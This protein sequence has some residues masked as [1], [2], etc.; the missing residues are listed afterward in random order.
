V[1]DRE[2][3]PTKSRVLLDVHVPKAWIGGVLAAVGVFLVV[4]VAGF[5]AVNRIETCD[6]CHLIRDEVATYKETAHYDAG[7]GCQ[8]CHTKP[9]VFNYLIR[10]LQG[11][12]NLI[13]FVSNTY[14]RPVTTHVGA[15][16]C[17]QCHSNEELERDKVVGNIRINHKGLREAGY[18]CLACH[19][20]ISH[21]GTQLAVARTSQNPMS[22]C[23]R[24][25]DGEQLPD[26]CDIC[27]IGGV[28]ATAP[29]V[30]MDVRIRPAQ[31]AGCHTGRVF[32]TDCH[33]GLQMPHPTRWN[34]QHGGVVLD[35]G[36]NICVSC[37]LKDDKDFCIDCH[38]VPM[39]HPSGYRSNHGS[40]AQNNKA[41]CEK[42]HGQNSCIRCHGLQMPHPSGWSSS[43]TG[44]G[45]SS[46]SLCT[47][48]HST[49]YCTNCH[50]VSMPHSSGFIADHPAQT[51]RNGSVC[52]KCHGN[53]GSGPGGCY[54]G[55]CH[56][57][58]ITP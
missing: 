34:R 43:H 47:R 58:G 42:C 26:D 7:V 50:G 23:A 49:S 40:F 16:T 28:P 6:T 30:A 41:K 39:P 27:H 33:N 53:A 2:R 10:N 48:C 25:H 45:R 54:G 35:R 31:C 38:G 57:N 56:S 21:P 12:T 20:D 11:T 29:K 15:D 24:C 19:A 8:K 17:A 14:E 18:Q 32:C 4:A 22:I 52:V 37:H 13:L 44:P 46:P 1:A 51:V 36:R 3:K 9:G 5:A 55:E